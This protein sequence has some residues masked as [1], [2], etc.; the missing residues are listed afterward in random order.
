MADEGVVASLK[1]WAAVVGIALGTLA[2]WRQRIELRDG[3]LYRR[4][5]LRWLAIA[6]ADIEE[7]TLPLRHH[8]PGLP[9]QGPE[10][11]NI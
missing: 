1:A 11:E 5:F 10:A 2:A 3:T 7:V 9:P 8:R 4:R 6:A